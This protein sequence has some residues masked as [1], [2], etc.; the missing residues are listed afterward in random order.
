MYVN[1]LTIISLDYLIVFLIKHLQQGNLELR[2]NEKY[3]YPLHL[4]CI[5]Q[6]CKYMENIAIALETSYITDFKKDTAFCAQRLIPWNASTV[7]K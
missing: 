3:N 1:A 4:L 2:I 7:E 6:G 5:L